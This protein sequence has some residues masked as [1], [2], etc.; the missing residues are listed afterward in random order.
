MIYRKI[1]L[2]F[3]FAGVLCAQMSAKEKTKFF[4]TNHS[5]IQYMGRVETRNHQ[6]RYNWPGTV[7]N[8]RFSGSVLGIQMKGGARNYFNVWIDEHL[9]GKIHAVEDT[10]WWL[11]A[12]LTPGVHQ[13]CLVKRTEA[14]MGMAVFY[15][16]YTGKNDSIL[17]PFPL[18]ERKL[19]FIGNSITCG[20]GTEG[21]NRS[22]R[23]KPATENCEM[24]YATILARAFNS[25]YH[26]IAHSGLGMVR[27]YGHAEKLSDQ[28]KTMPAR[29]DYL[30][31]N[32]STQR[33]NMNLYR[34]DA[35]V[36]NLGTNDFSTRPFPDESD[37]VGTGIR[38]IQTI[39]TIYPGVKVF[40]ITGPMIDEPCYSFTKKIVESVRLSMKTTDVVFIG[41]PVDLLN[42]EDDLGSDSHP[43]YKGQLK[44][45]GFI[46][47]VMANVLDWDYSDKEIKGNQ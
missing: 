35:V 27:N 28:S 26:L 23:F 39:R 42:P 9:S 46:L 12:Q 25:Q 44:T 45:A 31:D 41:V 4:P 37:F 11:P 3:L 32:D 29:L 43:S 40:C 10:V 16:I 21:L 2:L 36:V 13:L 8:V 14:D 24:S 22:E 38:L 20:Y 1:I 33:F 7:V 30:F 15:G 34:P 18:S 6:T 17:K 5:A 47:P 19:L